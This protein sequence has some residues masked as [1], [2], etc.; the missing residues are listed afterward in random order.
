MKIPG[1]SQA[2]KA[3][4]RTGSCRR[5]PA[6][7]RPRR[8]RMTNDCRRPDRALVRTMG[9]RAERT[10]VPTKEHQILDL[11]HDRYESSDCAAAAEWIGRIGERQR[12]GG[13]H[14]PERVDD[15]LCAVD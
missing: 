14:T 5:Y 15:D 4:T 2:A 8:E 7:V 9:N 3:R 11:A 13:V 6:A 12:Y 10:K 1:G